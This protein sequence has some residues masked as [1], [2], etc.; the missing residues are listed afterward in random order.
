MTV[1]YFFQCFSYRCLRST[2]EIVLDLPFYVND[3][4]LVGNLRIHRCKST[5]YGKSTIGN[6]SSN[7]LVSHIELE[8]FKIF[9]YILLPLPVTETKPYNFLLYVFAVHEQ[10]FSFWEVISINHEIMHV[11]KFLVDTS[12]F[13]SVEM[14]SDVFYDTTL[15]SSCLLRDLP[16]WG[17]LF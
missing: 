2:G 16:C 13:V 10:Y 3:A 14:M 7:L 8:E 12:E 9:N 11:R 6:A 15:I 5:C 17:S 4:S 1:W